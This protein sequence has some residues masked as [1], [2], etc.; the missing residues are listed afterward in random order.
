MD[1]ERFD[2]LARNVYARHSRRDLMLGAVAL[3]LS[4]AATLPRQDD[5]TAGKNRKKGKNKKK[6]RPPA[7]PPPPPPPCPACAGTL[8]RVPGSCDCCAGAGTTCLFDT[9][10]GGECFKFTPQ[11]EG[12]CL[13]LADGAACTFDAQCAGGYCANGECSPFPHHCR[14]GRLSANETA[15]RGGQALFGGDRLP[16]R[17]V[18]ERQMRGLHQRRDVRVRPEGPLFL[19]HTRADRRETVRP[20]RLSTYR[21]RLRRVRIVRDLLADRN[22]VYLLLPALR[23]PVESRGHHDRGRHGNTHSDAAA[24]GRRGHQRQTATCREEREWIDRHFAE[25]SADPCCL[26]RAPRSPPR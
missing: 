12:T 19:P 11:D 17:I 14:D 1:D 10:C 23:R 24:I 4:G 13:G 5:V 7:N 16:Q 18:R 8:T 26:A 25:S 22:V 20:E 6:K 15:M 9:C 2:D 21:R 3:T